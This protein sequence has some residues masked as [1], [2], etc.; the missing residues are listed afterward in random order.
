MNEQSVASKGWVVARLC[1]I[2]VAAIALNAASGAGVCVAW[3]NLWSAAAVLLLVARVWLRRESPLLRLADLAVDLCGML[4]LGQIA[5]SMASTCLAMRSL[6]AEAALA[7]A[8]AMAL[9]GA[10]VRLG[11]LLDGGRTGIQLTDP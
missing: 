2:G 4:L 8:F 10:V 1:A 11:L 7:L 6:L 5:L 3:L 9:T